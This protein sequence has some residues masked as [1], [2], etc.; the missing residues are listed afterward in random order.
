M[1]YRC[2]GLA[3]GPWILGMS[4]FLCFRAATLTIDPRRIALR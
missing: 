4:R 3:P 2:G 1:K